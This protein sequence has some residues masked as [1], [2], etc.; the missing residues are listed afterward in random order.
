[1]RFCLLILLFCGVGR[2]H[3]DISWVKLESSTPVYKT[4]DESSALL[5][6]ANR[7]ERI[8]VRAEKNGFARVQI[9]RGGKWRT[10][11]I[12]LDELEVQTTP[13]GWGFGG[14]GMY[15]Y[16]RHTGKKFETEDQVNYNTGATTST[17]VSS[18]LAAQSGRKNFWRVIL[19]YRLT[20]FN[21]MA[22]TDVSGA[23]SKKVQ[24][25]YSMASGVLQK[26]WTPLSKP[27]FYCGLGVEISRAFSATLKIDNNKLPVDQSTLPNFVGGQIIVGE[28]FFIA[29]SISLFIEGRLLGYPNQTPMIFGAELASGIVYWP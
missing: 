14:G 22:S 9:K 6:M 26:L 1:M 23:P 12:R 18:W 8:A 19:A 10:G 13:Q 21:S 4:G 17:A 15:S 5:V 25:H 2:T 28:Q 3:A 11:Y 7:G 29:K 16:L 20:D 24:L 27:N